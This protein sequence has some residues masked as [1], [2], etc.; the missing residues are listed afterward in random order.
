MDD[1]EGF[2]QRDD[3]D[4]EREERE[5]DGNKINALKIKFAKRGGEPCPREEER[6]GEREGEEES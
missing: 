4:V 2:L 3:I 6:E 5:R 1:F